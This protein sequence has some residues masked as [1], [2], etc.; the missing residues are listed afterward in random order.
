LS[1]YQT[2]KARLGSYKLVCQIIRFGVTA[3]KNQNFLPIIGWLGEQKKI[4]FGQLTYHIDSS[5]HLIM[6]KV[7]APIFVLSGPSGSG[8][9]TLLKK[10]FA[11]YPDTFGFSISR[12]LMGVLPAC[13]G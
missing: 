7:V 10:L 6:P 13:F 5:L 11:E 9:S 2:L 3:F 4:I 8:K 1:Y 12:K